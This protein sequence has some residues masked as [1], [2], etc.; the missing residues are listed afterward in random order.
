M[1]VAWISSEVAPWSKT[2]GLGDVSGA[3]PRALAEAGAAQVFVLSP[4]YRDLCHAD[5][6]WPAPELARTF[7][8]GGH[9][10]HGTAWRVRHDDRAEHLFL[11]CDGLFER[12]GIYGDAHG[13]YDDNAWRYG[14][15]CH[16]AALLVR[17]LG[18]DIVHANDWQT[19]LLPAFL[20]PGHLLVFT[21]HNI[22]FQGRFSM[23]AFRVQGIAAPGI[24]DDLAFWDGA[25]T[26]KLALRRADAVT[27]VS[28]TYARE[29][30]TPALGFGMDGVLAHDVRRLRG[31]LNG[32]DPS[33]DPSID[34]VLPAR[35]DADRLDGKAACR[36]HLWTS[37]GWSAPPA[38]SHVPVIGLIARL[39]RQKG[40]DLALPVLRELLSENR[41]RVALLGQGEA[42]LEHEVRDLAE[43]WPDRC[44]AHVGYSEERARLIE[45][46]SD[47]F[48]MPS[49]FEPCG[50]NQMYSMRYGTLPVVHRVGG[51]AD[52]VRDCDHDPD[53]GTGFTFAPATS[54]ALSG[55]VERAILAWHD[56]GRWHSSMQNA[57]RQDF[58]WARSAEQFMT[59]Y[60]DL[61]SAR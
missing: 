29:I 60:G 35:F 58:S 11:S 3:L 55:A 26:M 43:I 38:G 1:R 56:P 53:H 40:V 33:W 48:L 57:M 10:V 16:Y 54:E 22:L 19:G 41:V 31:I 8:H 44:H 21:I 42:D 49:R 14:V 37:A 30:C 51:L 6:L 45:A 23:D 50:L 18:A 39:T 13:G 32:I 20:A 59:L 36:S 9:E 12:P 28:P 52:T 47:I 27:T 2:G 7:R 24:L 61:W 17:E 25:S 15:F 46:G 4:R 5:Q 34:A